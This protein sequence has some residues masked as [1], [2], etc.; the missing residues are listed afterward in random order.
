MFNELNMCIKKFFFY[1]A[2]IY[3]VICLLLFV[4]QRHLI[5]LP[6]KSTENFLS[7][8]L[9]KFSEITLITTDNHKIN[10]WYKN[11]ISNEP[12][13]LF[14]HGNAGNLSHRI[15]K[16][17]EFTENSNYGLFAI[18]YRGYGKSTGIP[19]EKGFYIDAQTAIDY[20]KNVK[21]IE[22]KDIILY[23]ESIGSGVA[24]K[25]ATLYNVR[26]VILEAP[27]TSIKDVANEGIFKF[28]PLSLMLNEKFPSIDRI[29]H[30]LSPILIIHGT[31]DKVIAPMH[32]NKLFKKIRH[33]RKRIIFYENVGH[34]NINPQRVINDIKK[35]EQDF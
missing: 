11:A 12:T 24:V 23:G 27:F 15:N 32:S 5:Y 29:G 16:F 18:D 1:S 35:L 2:T 9:N 7:Y 10:A 21:G 17:I 33:N 20:L 28:F 19:S 4:F 26:S 8:N 13:I 22:S 30:V 14:F 31:E 34:N 6:I 25:M 3:I